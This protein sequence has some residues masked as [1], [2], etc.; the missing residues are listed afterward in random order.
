MKSKWLVLGSLSFSIGFGF[1]IPF[2]NNLEKSL[3]TGL[4]ASISTLS[5]AA[6]L[7]KFNRL[8][9]DLCKSRLYLSEEKQKVQDEFQQIQIQ[10]SSASE[11]LASIKEQLKKNQDLN[12]RLSKDNILFETKKESIESQII[13]LDLDLVNK[14]NDHKYLDEE[15]YRL[16]NNKSNIE[17]YLSELNSQKG[18]YELRG[19]EQESCLRNIETEIESLESQK[20][21]L[22]ST[23]E[24]LNKE[25]KE[26]SQNETD[27]RIAI[28]QLEFDR[29]NMLKKNNKL[30]QII[31]LSKEKE[32][33]Q[34]EIEI[35]Q[36]QK[37]LA[38]ESLTNILEQFNDQKEIYSKLSQDNTQ[39]EL[40]YRSIESQV[41]ALEAN[42]NSLKYQISTLDLDLVSHNNTF[43]DIKREID[44]LKDN[45][46]TIEK[47]L[48]DSLAQ[49][50]NYESKTREQK[51]NLRQIETELESLELQRSN[52]FNTIETLNKEILDIRQNKSIIENDL[53]DLKMEKNKIIIDN[54]KLNEN[55]IN[56]KS[57]E[58]KKI[59]EIDE[60]NLKLEQ[61]DK[62]GNLFV[63]LDELSLN[64]KQK[65]IKEICQKRDIQICTHFTRIENLSSI[66]EKGL[67]PRA[68][69]E[70][71]EIFYN[72]SDRWDGQKNANCL[73]VSF[74]NYKMFYRYSKY[75]QK[76]WVVLS[77]RK[78]ILWEMKC[79]FCSANA[80]KREVRSISIHERQTVEA[81]KQMFLGD[82][83]SSYPTNVQAEVLVF[84]NIQS[85][86]LKE[87]TFYSNE[88]R[89]SWVKNNSIF[90]FNDHMFKARH[91]ISPGCL[92]PKEANIH[93]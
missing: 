7:K 10:K 3:S 18:D 88:A 9:E 49:Q 16:K 84:D 70:D 80:A 42:K 46:S 59:H 30:S 51:D 8:D 29:A 92:S 71:N 85:S 33:I 75:N 40:H 25:I 11:S 76:D 26:I 48:K 82:T 39:L 77:Y 91:Q 52:L 83:N 61:L 27:I 41:S 45:K 81:F 53:S 90:Q 17:K 23:I 1:S 79:A 56:L 2:N 86:Y 74:P 65:E 57:Q 50:K 72:D 73:S 14:K 31:N 21:S 22:F 55:L 6:I 5:A 28:S 34:K 68:Y 44:Q 35:A 63:H 87:V 43:E 58:K 67:I 62:S 54:S 32:K 93:N 37:D 69:L 36:S 13:A 60:L 66:L 20:S 19:R 64:K 89:D 24:V 47:Y 12:A 15:I 4:C 78:E 38:N